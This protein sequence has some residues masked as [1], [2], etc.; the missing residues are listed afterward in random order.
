MKNLS[1]EIDQNYKAFASAWHAEMSRVYSVIATEDQRFLDCYKRLVSLQAW[2]AELL[3][4]LIV[5]DA[6]GFFLEAQNDGLVS[7]VLARLGSHRAALQSL[8]SCLENVLFAAFYMDHPV[9]L[10]LWHAGKQKL[11]FSELS[12]YFQ[13]HPDIIGVDLALHVLQ[14]MSNEYATLSRAVHGSAKSFRMTASEAGTHLWSDDK[15]RIG[16]YA[17]RQSHT[18]SAINELLL[19][20]FRSHLQGASKL[21]LRKAIS[22]A[23][24]QSR[25][26]KIR[27]AIG[28]RLLTP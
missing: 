16:M 17:T 22:Y 1:Q 28:V 14:E 9:E 11:G 8:R 23:V 3:E 25:H 15:A 13:S 20:L 5:P 26:D 19:L 18:V 7:L 21:N 10:R 2:R 12:S 27:D 6:L 4:S 24:P